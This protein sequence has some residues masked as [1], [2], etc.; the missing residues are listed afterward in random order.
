MS[1]NTNDYSLSEI[2]DVSWIL[3]NSIAVLTMQV[4]F[5]VLE[6]GST[7]KS[8]CINIMLKNLIDMCI[9]SIS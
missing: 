2:D 3:S 7:K 6:T 8:H 5:A 4:G 1:N 9:S